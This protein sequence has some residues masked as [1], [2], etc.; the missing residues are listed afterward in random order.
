MALTVSTN[1]RGCTR[2]AAYLYVNAL[3][4]VLNLD[5][6]RVRLEIICGKANRYRKCEKAE[7]QILEKHDPLVWEG[8]QV[9]HL[10]N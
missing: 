1:T 6:S 8:E 3:E 4:T 10:S 2:D 9:Q 7:C 5:S